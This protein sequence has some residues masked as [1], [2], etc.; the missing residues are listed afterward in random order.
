M[1][2]T[3]SLSVEAWLDGEYDAE[4]KNT[5]LA[6]KETNPTE[7]IDAFYKTLDFGTGGLRGLMGVGTNRLNVYTIRM[8]TQGLAD[9]IRR[10]PALDNNNEHSVIIGYDCRHNSRLFAEEAAKV[11]AGNG[12]RAYI[13]RALRPC[14]LVSFGCRYK[15]CTAGI[16]ITASHNPPQYNGFKVYWADGAQ[17]L[18]PHDR[19][20]IEA[21]NLIQDPSQV[22]IA[23]T[24]SDRHIEWIDTEID[25]AY[26]DAVAPLA[27][28]PKEDLAYGDELNIVYS[29]LHGTGIT[30]VPELLRR[31]GF[32]TLHLVDA[33]SAV[34]GSFS[35]V[36]S[37]NPEDPAAMAMGVKILEEKEADIFVATDPDADRVGIAVRHHG[38]VELLN[39]NQIACLCLEGICQAL[40]KQ[41]RLPEG[42]TFVKSVVTTELFKAIATAY[43]KACYETLPGFKYIGALIRRWESDPKEGHEYI[44]GAE[45]SFGYLF[46]TQARDKDAVLTIALLCELALEAKREGKTLVD[47]L[48]DLYHRYGVYIE[49]QLSVNFEDSKVGN[50]QMVKQMEKIVKNPPIQIAGVVVKETEDNPAAK[51]VTF[52]LSD[53]SKLIIR[54]SGTEPKIKTY[55]SVLSPLRESLET[56]MRTLDAH[57]SKLL[58]A[59]EALLTD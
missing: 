19:G 22:K 6:L 39:G 32:S 43:G 54:P 59:M 53:H 24:L 46:G 28:Y 52:F 14:P 30:L 17:V 47:R 35:T 34:D 21:F 42:A 51:M 13:F 4:T 16:M 41:G 36:K 2:E 15:Q 37:P 9:Y 44:F 40:K 56:T 25:V 20:I 23:E 18:P 3:I 7:L 8:A 45:E 29:S 27:L 48:H 12:I 38:K 50:E 1:D 55:C 49:K 33:Q 26:F 58:S 31:W 11:L 10:Q 5:I 57:A